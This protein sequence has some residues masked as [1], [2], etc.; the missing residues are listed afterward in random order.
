MRLKAMSITEKEAATNPAY[1]YWLGTYHA[2]GMATVKDPAKA[3]QW[4]TKSCEGFDPLGCIAAAKALST[5]TQ[6]GDSEKARVYFQRACAAGV[7]DGCKGVGAPS[8]SK[9]Q[10]PTP[11]RA[12][13]NGCSTGA[14]AGLVLG[15]AA[16]L[17]RRR[18]RA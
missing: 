10:G 7:E 9:A 15:F 6:P 1:M 11:V 13:S 3:L 18:R 12:K 8:P 16:L 4:F 17:L 5:S 2:S 14:D